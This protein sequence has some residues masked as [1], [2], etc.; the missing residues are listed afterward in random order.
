MGNDPLILALDLGSGGATAALIGTDLRVRTMHES[1][2]HF[3][4][5]THGAATLAPA[6]VDQAVNAAVRACLKDGPPPQALAL[7]SMMHTLL[8]TDRDGNPR[9]PIFTW[10]DSRGADE[11]ALL[12]ET[13]GPD[14]EKRTGTHLHPS[15]PSIKLA[16]LKMT[17]PDLFERGY[18]IASM[19]SYVQWLL[20]GVW[21]EDTSSASAS[22]L[23]GLE[24]G[25]WDQ[26]YL[27]QIGITSESLS[28]LVGLDHIVGSLSPDACSRLGTAGNI[29]VIAGGGDGFL[30]SLG[31]GCVQPDRTSI[32][33]G[34][35]SA[36]RKTVPSAGFD[37]AS[38][39]F[40]YRSNGKYL[41][42][43]A[44]NNGG[45]VLDWGR[46][47]F[48]DAPFDPDQRYDD[49]LIFLPFLYGERSPFWNS[50]QV[51]R[52]VGRRDDHSR[53]E[54]AEAVI[55]GLAFHL[56]VYSEIVDRA[57]ESPTTTFV[58][59]G[60]GSRDKGARAVLA[61]A[62]GAPLVLP[63]DA[64]LATLRGA[65]RCG[66]AALGIDTSSAME[67][68]VNKGTTVTPLSDSGIQLRFE[69]FRSAYFGN[70]S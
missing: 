21:S 53:E 15:F 32:T 14:Y 54:L 45:N 25:D 35:T 17:R 31:S 61:A 5:D 68:L 55:E 37:P 11:V 70:G 23:L 69:R 49:I 59:S 52:W 46:D 33:I 34:T 2:W 66:L 13:L 63:E 42:G 12:R 27:E 4:E 40:C 22:G 56:A 9:T 39:T 18:R 44:S 51:S 1:V 47:N 43:C 48:G 64:G 28:E 16:W 8:L 24:S 60:N 19:R 20:S 57:T 3:D 38:G 10:L 26:G 65:A 41:V 7:S 67:G 58:L 30:A 50:R 36:V 29:P 62:L 6:V